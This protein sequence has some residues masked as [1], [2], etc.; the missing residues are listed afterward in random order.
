MNFVKCYCFNLEAIE[1]FEKAKADNFKGWLIHHRLETH[2]SDGELRDVDLSKEE[3]EA[4]GTYY[5]RPASELIF[6]KTSEHNTLHRKGKKMTK[7]SRERISK[8]QIGRKHTV[9]SRSLMSLHHSPNSGMKNMKHS[10]E[11]KKKMAEARRRYW[12]RKRN[13][14]LDQK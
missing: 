7:E 9:I 12:E 2:N 1:N 13:E 4:L 3:L 6:M 14:Q 10:E 8:A 11:S 5:M